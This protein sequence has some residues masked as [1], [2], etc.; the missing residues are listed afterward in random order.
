MK[1]ITLANQKGG[2]GKTI[3]AV[4]LAGALAFMGKKVLL[5]DMDPQGHAANA[6]GVTTYNDSRSSYAIFDKFLK[7][8][9]C[10]IQSLTHQ[11]YDN[12]VII[13]SH[14]SL[15]TIEQQ[16]SGK[17]GA[18]L[19]L[20][21]LLRQEELQ[22]FDFIIV[23]TAPYVGFLSLNCIYAADTLIV[24]IEVSSFSARGISHIN[25]L[26]DIYN[27]IER[28]GFDMRFLVT[29]YDSRSSFS[30]KFLK[31]MQDHHSDKLFKTVIR[32]NVAL[33]EAAY[34]G[35]VIFEHNISSHGAEDYAA[36]AR[37]IC[38]VESDNEISREFLAAE[39]KKYLAFFKIHAPEAA[40]VYVV[41]DFNNWRKDNNSAMTRLNDGTWIKRVPL[42]AGPHRYRFV[43]DDKWKIDPANPYTELDHFN[44][45]D[46][47][48]KI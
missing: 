18:T 29:L 5:I 27:K 28:K 21:N 2:C 24:P 17:E 47:L 48:L 40:T 46:S 26:L 41:G 44:E 1:I 20:R 25:I 6:L 13:P 10:D 19:I 16:L 39:V 15:C 30:K 31:K 14:I 32:S 37:E 33:R 43:I 11:R 22:A 45:K 38:P 36:L 23:D 4:N 42:P 9:K 35:K 34:L 8:E 7:D 12:L 3:T